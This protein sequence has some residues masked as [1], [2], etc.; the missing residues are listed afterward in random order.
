M[1]RSLGIVAIACA[2]SYP[3]AARAQSDVGGG[4]GGT[5]TG[6]FQDPASERRIELGDDAESSSRRRRS[7]RGGDSLEERL[8]LR[9]RPDTLGEAA[10]EFHD[11]QLESLLR[12]REGLVEQRRALAIQ[13]LEEFIAEEPEE[14]DEMPDALLRLAELRW[15]QARADYIRAF[16]AWQQVPEENR[17]APPQPDYTA[18]NALYT[19]ASSSVIATSI[20]TTSSCT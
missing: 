2:L 14:A 12:D 1:I 6:R 20:A 17:G 4:R 5:T 19:I 10:R 7:R 16:A 8:Y 11:E 15:E 13:L 9:E 18:S 3:C